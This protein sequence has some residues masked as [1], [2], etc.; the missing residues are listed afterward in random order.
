MLT[1][2]V[3]K[4][5]EPTMGMLKVP[6][7]TLDRMVEIMKSGRDLTPEEIKTMWDETRAEAK[8][9]KNKND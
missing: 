9:N 1:S 4:D 7:K 2:L 8:A 3:R 5:N 6:E